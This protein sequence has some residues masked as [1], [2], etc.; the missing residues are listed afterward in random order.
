VRASVTDAA[1]GRQMITAVAALQAALAAAG[2]PK[3]E[4]VS[5]AQ[6]LVAGLPASVR[7]AVREPFG[8]RAVVYALLLDDDPGVVQTQ[9]ARLDGKAE[10]GVADLTLSLR[11]DVAAVDQRA[12]LPLVDMALPALRSL[13]PTQFAGFKA[14][15][16]ALIAADQRVDLF[17]WSLRRILLHQL[18]A[19][20]GASPRRRVLYH[21]L[22]KQ[23]LEPCGVLL[24]ALAHAGH[25][26]PA[27]AETAFAQASA[28]LALGESA[29]STTLRLLA[30]EEAEGDALD[31]AIDALAETA[32][33]VKRK[34]LSACA[35][36]IGA[37]NEITVAEAELFRAVAGG[38]GC[39][40]P[41]VLAGQ[42]LA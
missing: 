26:D 19:G 5:Y 7:D 35:V 40:I 27:A 28:Q 30:A 41:P 23:L 21:A 4:H 37:D 2:Q 29:A 38:L 34:L 11:A 25:E 8:A 9:L 13:S 6:E 24:S 10:P 15:L 36:C 1:S 32:P 20:T 31:R 42:P 33:K 16:D 17:E 14:N 22:G 3:P 12:R 18:A 39:P